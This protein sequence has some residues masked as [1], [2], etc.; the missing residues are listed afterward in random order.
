MLSQILGTG[1]SLIISVTITPEHRGMARKIATLS[2]SPPKCGFIKIDSHKP[3]TWC[4]EVGWF[5]WNLSCSISLLHV[6][7]REVGGLLSLGGNG[8][9]KKIRSAQWLSNYLEHVLNPE[10][11]HPSYFR[12]HPFLLT[13]HLMILLRD[14]HKSHL[15]TW[16]YLFTKKDSVVFPVCFSYLDQY[17]RIP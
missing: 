15:L 9:L 4:T 7:S 10:S 2:Q 12:I 8:F 13:Q 1:T 16:H 5:V 17:C 3:K 14:I 6:H 11:Y